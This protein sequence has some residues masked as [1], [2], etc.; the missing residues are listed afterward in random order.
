MNDESAARSA[1]EAEPAA[2][3]ADRPRIGSLSR[4]MIGIAA[5]W[6][7]ALLLT[8]GF[9]L[10]RVLSRSMKDS[11]DNQMEFLLNS[12]IALSASKR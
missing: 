2:K 8:G 3:R 9:A 11:F 7:V 5:L 4:R 1:A 6:I 12:L 10:D